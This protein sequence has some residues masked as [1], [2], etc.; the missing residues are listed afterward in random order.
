MTPGKQRPIDRPIDPDQKARLTSTDASLGA[1][2]EC[3]VATSR[4]VAVG[5]RLSGTALARLK[6]QLTDRDWAIIRS[7]DNFRVLTGRQL[8]VLHFDG[9]HATLTASTRSCSRI[10]TRLTR[11]RV[12]VRLPRAQGGLKGGSA[13]FNY[14]I[15]PAG[16]RLLDRHQRQG[17]WEPSPRLIAHQLAVADVFVALVAASKADQL[18]LVRYAAEPECWRAIPGGQEQLRPDLF[19]VLASGEYEYHWWLEIDQG[20][21]HRATLERRCQQYLAYLR[22]GH[23]QVDGGVFPRVAWLTTTSQ[24]AERLKRL[25][26]AIQGE[27]PLFEVGLL[28]KP[29]ALLV[30]EGTST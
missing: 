25:T 11:S 28:D 20:N 1:G 7:I 6:Q 29:L 13:S 3:R 18:Q 14:V 9:A 22:S 12:L 10:L 21:E 24:R 15:G 5:E 27:L 26:Q 4:S 16:R 23:E 17:W 8:Q 2:N 19:V 30:P